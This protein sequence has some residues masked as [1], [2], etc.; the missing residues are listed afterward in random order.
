MLLCVRPLAA[1]DTTWGGLIPYG[2]AA[3]DKE[4]NFGNR[5]YNDQ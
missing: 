5:A 2:D 3:G 4:T 1:A